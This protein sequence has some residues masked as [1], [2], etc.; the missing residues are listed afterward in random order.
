M[1][2]VGSSSSFTLTRITNTLQR[3]M[4]LG[5]MNQSLRR[6]LELQNQI[7]TGRRINAPSDDPIG[8]NTVME[9][10]H[11][12]EKSERYDAN[13][14]TGLQKLG[15]TEVALRGLNDIL[16]EAKIL[17]LQEVNASATPETRRNAAIAVDGMLK[18][19]ISIANRK[20]GNTYLFGG[21]QTR[22]A[23]FELL[24]GAVAYTGDEIE[25]FTNVSDGI[26]IAINMSGAAAFGA[27]STEIR[28]SADLNPIITLETKLRDLSGGEGVAPGSIMVTDGTDTTYIDLSS[29]ESIGD[30][31]DI[32]NNDAA[33]IVTASIN[34]AQDGLELVTGLGPI[35][36]YEVDGGTTA[37]D[38]GIRQETVVPG[39]LVGAD[40]DP[41]VKET[42]AI[43]DLFGGAGLTNPA[44]DLTISNGTKTATINFAG[45]TTVQNMLNIINTCGAGVTAR[46]ND[47]GTGIDIVSNLNGARLSI[48]DTGGTTA[49]ELGLLMG[50]A[51]TKL[52]DLNDGIGVSTV[53]GDDL[54]ITRSDG[55]VVEVDI[56][57]AT[58][59]QDVIDLINNDSENTGGLLV[60]SVA[61]TGDRLA[62]T[63]NSGGPDDLVVEN[64][65]GSFAASNLGVEGTVANGPA[66]MV[67]TGEDLSPAGVQ[68][69][70]IFTA[71]IRLRD[72]LLADDTD[73]ISRSGGM[74]GTAQE[75]MLNSV[76]EVGT[77]GQ[78][79][80]LTQNRLEDEKVHLERLLSH[81][82]DVNL[83]ETIT[84]F[85]N[86][87]IVYQAGLAT[88]ATLLQNSL[89]NFL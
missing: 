2:I 25:L 4:L 49:S 61:G 26:S 71:L 17:M 33:G 84:K 52:A 10:Q 62:L 54:R 11:A 51:R 66:P 3:N 27:L 19:A 16:T 58:T 79:L 68:T 37:G 7:A 6:I 29:A 73:A 12:L 45:A 32:I 77:R 87:Q 31:V 63:D 64:I 40:L 8:A 38:L 5:S 36:V 69:E 57:D 56:S 43:A 72:A 14:Q 78:R 42:T 24:S 46:I 22:T 41:L 18:G 83:A 30:V 13:V 15:L 50:L 76:A 60:A 48:E 34:A 9:L 85:Q 89:L 75:R 65:N 86:E 44:A 81:T 88:A 82:L 55:T 23:P 74:I 35:G 39:P 21:A 53:Y 20:Y 67:M 59:V 80:E 47:S 28:G 1:G 70:S